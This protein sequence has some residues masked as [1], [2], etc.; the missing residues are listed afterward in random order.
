MQGR[1]SAKLGMLLADGFDGT[2]RNGGWTWAVQ[3]MARGWGWQRGWWALLLVIRA[4]VGMVEVEVTTL[5]RV[6]LGKLVLPGDGT[7]GY[8]LARQVGVRTGRGGWRRC[9]VLTP[10]C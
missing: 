6:L 9:W 3:R 10:A 2:L 1:V 5:V 4:K 8:W 7:V